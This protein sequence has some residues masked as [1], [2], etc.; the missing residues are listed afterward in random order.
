[1]TLR[2]IA[3]GGGVQSSAL[4]VLAARGDIDFD[5]SLFCNVGDDSEYPDTLSYVREVMTPWAERQVPGVDVF[6]LRKRWRR[7]KRKGTDAP[8]LWQRLHN[9]DSRSVEIPVRMV[10]T[11]APGT[12]NCTATYKIKVIDAW[13]RD[14]G[15]NADHPAT[16]AIGIST[17]EYQ[18]AGNRKTKPHENVVYPL[19]D[20]GLSRVDCMTIISDAGLPVPPKSACFFCPF[21]RPQHWAEMRRDRPD[22]FN[23]SVD[24]ETTLNERRDKLGKDHVYLTRFG[25]PLDV[26]VP[27]AQPALFGS[28]AWGM[29]ND[30]ECDDGFCFV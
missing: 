18:R 19:L 25:K 16:I 11:G 30:G 22:L 6:E 4:T 24:L 20:L 2:V 29:D 21:H 12:R 13:I 10:D 8:T 28:G 9:P 23:K 15:A 17:D 27:V 7:G 26:A 1:M 5:T 14:A 3:Y